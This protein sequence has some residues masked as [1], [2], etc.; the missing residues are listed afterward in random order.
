MKKHFN[1]RGYAKRTIKA[2]LNLIFLLSNITVLSRPFACSQKCDITCAKPLSPNSKVH[3]YINYRSQGANTARELVGWQTEIYRPD[4]GNCYGVTTFTFEYMQSFKSNQIADN[5]FGSSC[6]T[7][8]GSDINPRA[9]YAL[10]AEYFG[11]S[12]EFSGTICFNPKIENFIFDW[13]IFLG[14]D[15]WYPGL[16]FRAHLPLTHSRWSLFDNDNNCCIN[17][18]PSSTN[19]SPLPECLIG[20]STTTE[21]INSIKDAFVCGNPVDGQIFGANQ[22]GCFDCCRMEDTKLAD[23][24]LILGW[25]AYSNNCGHFG[26]FLQY[27]APTGT[28]Y[29]RNRRNKNFGGTYFTPQ[30][31]NG[32]HNE[33]GG[34]ITC[35]T[36][37]WDDQKYRSI[38]FYFE[39]NVTHMFSNK[40]CRLFDLC[41]NGAYS[42]YILLRE[43]ES[44][45][46]TPTGKLVR[47]N[48]TEIVNKTLDI[49]IDAKVDF[50]FK[51]VYC[52]CGWA[53]DL[54]Y[55]IYYHSKETIANKCNLNNN[56]FNNNYKYG[57][58][59]LTGACCFNYDITRPGGI[60]FVDTSTE[61]VN[62]DIVATVPNANL[63]DPNTGMVPEADVDTSGS[64]ICLAWNSSSPTPIPPSTLVACDLLTAEDGFRPIQGDLTTPVILGENVINLD[65][66]LS[67]AV[68]SNKIFGHLNYMWAD[69]CGWNPFLGI[70][71]EVEFG[72]NTN[73]CLTKNNCNNNNNNQIVGL[74]QWGIWIKGGFSF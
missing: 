11:L 74:N 27:V 56:C 12:P 72:D 36:M 17:N 53:F 68:L 48:N 15:C 8:Q 21:P 18:C 44:D 5:W 40:Q 66:G 7:F 67:P 62:T 32:H 37:L 16:Y 45:G 50:S 4:T 52:H 55:N 39:G 34:G 69:K 51:F 2:T 61:T 9:D 42:R 46:V 1:F 23:I 10:V 26:I 60:C 19:T 14:L 59:G 63:F 49:K 41:N 29:S 6:L 43:F 30:I 13:N 58:A 64:S 71:F 70:G 33:L 22:S 38:A 35:H 28:D 65:S 31:G 73:N 25:L 20:T 47:A 54:G 24:D 57:V 3:T